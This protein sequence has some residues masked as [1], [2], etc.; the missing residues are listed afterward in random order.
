MFFTLVHFVANE[1]SHYTDVH[2]IE[3]P[4]YDLIGVPILV[5]NAQAGDRAG[6]AS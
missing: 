2:A 4:S 5:R 1:S 6:G 3:K